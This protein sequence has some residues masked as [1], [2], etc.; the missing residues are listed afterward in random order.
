MNV[1]VDFHEDLGLHVVATLNRSFTRTVN[2]KEAWFFDRCPWLPLL[3]HFLFKEISCLDRRESNQFSWIYY[4][5]LVFHSRLSKSIVNTVFRSCINT[6]DESST[7]SLLWS[8]AITSLIDFGSSPL[9]KITRMRWQVSKIV[10]LNFN[11]M[12]VHV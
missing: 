8:I 12:Y 1:R 3:R 10:A 11:G 6:L 2:S 5:P 9:I 7:C 4:V